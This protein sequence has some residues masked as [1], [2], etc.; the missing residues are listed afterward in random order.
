VSFDVCAL[1]GS[2]AA[3]DWL[4]AAC[5]ATATETYAVLS[6]PPAGDRSY[7]SDSFEELAALEPRSFW[8]R[9]RNRLLVWAFTRYFSDARRMLEI[10]CGTGY[11]LRALRGALP[12]G[13]VVGAELYPGGLRIARERL[14]GVALLQADARVLDLEH[15]FDVVG[16]FDVL[17]HIDDDT[18]ALA[19]LRRAVVPGG[20]L[21]V[22]V[23][24]H[25]WLWSEADDFG[26][27]KR[28]YSRVELIEKVEEA[29]FEPLLTTS[30]VSFLL[31]L[32][33]VDRLRPRTGSTYDFRREFQR[34][35][36]LDRALEGVMSAEQGLIR[37]GISLPFGGSLLLVA[38]SRK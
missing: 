36:V 19:A 17:E 3:G 25:A 37:A 1:C 27:H 31:P 5:R 4:C 9:S 12:S 8:F 20:G 15:V 14:P 28:R 2:S 16:A 10:G 34:A 23:P 30:F 21:L 6:E 13:E 38:R 24:Q 22:T 33:A 29:G 32:M 18:G 35:P 11:V 26:A 7:A